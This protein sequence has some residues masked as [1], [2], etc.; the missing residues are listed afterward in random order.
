MVGIIRERGIS[1]NDV[2]P[3]PGA[4][5]HTALTGKVFW[6]NSATSSIKVIKEGKI[7]SGQ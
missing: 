1:T 5:I 7:I 6:V 3:L 4:T 2:F